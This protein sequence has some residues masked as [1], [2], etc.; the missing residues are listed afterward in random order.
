MGTEYLS[1]G[2]ATAVVIALV[3][4]CKKA[5]FPSKFAGVLSVLFGILAALSSGVSSG[6]NDYLSMISS[7]VMLGLIASGAYSGSKA[8]VSDGR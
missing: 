5:G 8:V 3:A 4:V 2:G 6:S 1:L 7:G